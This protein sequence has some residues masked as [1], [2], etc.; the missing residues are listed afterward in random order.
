MDDR[1]HIKV[2]R[3]MRHDRKV[4]R[5]PKAD[6]WTLVALM[7]AAEDIDSDCPGALMVSPVIPMTAED[8]ADDI[9]DDAADVA[10]VLESAEALGVMDRGGP[11]G[12]WRFVSYE[13]HQR[14]RESETRP[15]W[16]ERK[17][18][19]RDRKAAEREAILA[20]AAECAAHVSTP[21][22]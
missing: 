4:R 21:S 6:R 5:L 2:D 1:R 20:L 12:A 10:R 7:L 19:E 22:S 18:K 17:R 11:C 14:T 9:G 3:E 16:A 8:M 13:N 15:A